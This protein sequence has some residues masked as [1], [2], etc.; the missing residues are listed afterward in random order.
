MATEI[1]RKS[2]S[3]SALRTFFVSGMGT[4]LEFY[5]FV[6]YGTAAALVFPR[7]FFPQMDPLTA[8]LVAFG[9][10][11]AGFFARPLGGM[12]F[13]HYGD[14]LGRQKML[15]ITLLLMGLST[16]LIGCLPGY[17]TLGAGAPVLLVLLRLVQGF[18]AGGEWGGAALF[19]IESAP[20]GRRGLWGS[21]TSMGIGIGGILGAGVFA[22]VSVAS[23]DDLAGFAWRIPFWL[24]G[25]L[26]LI[27]LYARLHKPLEQPA[28]PQAHVRMPLLEALRARPRAML[29]CTGI[30]FGYVTIAYIGSTFFLSYATQLGYGSTDALIFD[31]SLSIAIVITAPLFALLSDRI[32][33][34]KV[35]VLGAVIMAL[36]FFAFFPLVGLKSLLMSTAAYIAIGAF[37]GATQGPIPAFLAEQFPRHMRYSG[38]SAAYQIGAALGGGTASSAATAILIANNHNAFGVAVYGAIALGIVALCSL[39]LKETAHL[40][41]EQID[42]ADWPQTA[43]AVTG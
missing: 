21:F 13:G 43:P 42:E 7:V 9:A 37:M 18:A 4:A 41:L 35:M 34:R 32:G 38:M 22:I 29:L 1:D 5:D 40:S 23:H 30:A 27:G 2:G 31:L 12:V 39:L 14:K 26:V 10:F 6:I 17:A 19:G 3:P 28:E 8:T 33:R 15:V 25:V 11:G 20:P 16:L 24:G 36:G